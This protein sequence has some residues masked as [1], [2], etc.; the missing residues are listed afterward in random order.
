MDSC[1]RR[2]D[3][4]QTM[5][6]ADNIREVK[7]RIRAAAM[8]VGRD[9]EGVRLVA[10]TKSVDVAKIKE[11]ISA[12]IGIIGENRVQ[13]ALPKIKEIGPIVSYHFI[14]HLQTNKVKYIVGLFDLIHSV[15][16]IHLA[17]EINRRSRATQK[18]LVEVNL[19]KEESKFGLSPEDTVETMKE[20]ARL[21]MVSVI[22]FMTIPP[23][24][25]DPERSRLYFRQLRELAE[26]IRGKGIKGI[27]MDE[28]S[29]GMSNDFEVAIEEGATI[30]RIGTAIFGPRQ[31]G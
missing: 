17:A 28:L 13:E 22:G 16:N 29:V 2:N 8:K 10:A 26:E 20:I 9:P 15:D 6:I 14:G 1:F 31:L 24:H 7:N 23:F 12:G 5:S 19:A 21:P 18:V 25:E 3:N 11:A 27:S 4:R 30:V